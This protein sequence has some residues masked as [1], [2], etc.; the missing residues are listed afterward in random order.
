MAACFF[1]PEPFA[2]AQVE[3]SLQSKEFPMKKTILACA[4]ALLLSTGS[5]FAQMQPAPGASSEGNVGPG[6]TKSTTKHMKKGTTTGMATGKKKA[7][8]HSSSSSSTMDKA[9]SGAQK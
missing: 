5:V 3:E 9:G 1:A 6:A 2:G 4:C 7:G 8:S